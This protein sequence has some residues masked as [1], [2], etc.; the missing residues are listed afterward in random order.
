MVLLYPIVL[1]GGRA[2]GPLGLKTVPRVLVRLEFLETLGQKLKGSF[3]W[4]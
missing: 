1:Q 2:V 4:R 3:Y